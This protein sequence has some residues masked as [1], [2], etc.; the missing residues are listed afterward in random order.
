M[1][2][3]TTLSQF[4]LHKLGDQPIPSIYNDIKQECQNKLKEYEKEF[5]NKCSE[6]RDDIMQKIYCNEL[7]YDIKPNEYVEHTPVIHIKVDEIVKNRK[8]LEQKGFINSHHHHY[9]NDNIIYFYY[10]ST[11]N[12]ITKNYPSEEYNKILPNNEYVIYL[13][14]INDKDPQN[15]KQIIYITNYGRFIKSYITTET[16][17]TN[18]NSSYSKYGIIYTYYNNGIQTISNNHTTIMK[19][20]C[21]NAYDRLLYRIPRLFIKIFEAY[22]NRDTNLLQ[23]CTKDYFIKHMESKKRMI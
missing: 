10:K 18:N 7:E 12:S 6:L 4:I 1:D 22:D 3:Y 21:T 23:E 8:L 19:I 14:F 16:Y 9:N 13:I 15:T 11:T 20:N 5:I 2:Q 17:Y